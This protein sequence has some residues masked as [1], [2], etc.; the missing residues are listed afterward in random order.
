VALSRTD[1]EIID[2]LVVRLRAEHD[3]RAANAVERLMQQALVSPDPR[4]ALAGYMT[5]GEAARLIGVSAQTI[6]NWVAHGR[7]VGNRV[8]G[9]ILVARRSVQSFFDALG[10]AADA[11][12]DEDSAGADAAQRNVMEELPTGLADRV[13]ELLDRQRAGYKLSSSERTEL[14]RLARQGTA[15]ATRRT[16]ARIPVGRTSRA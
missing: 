4:A 16:R 13:E 2:E 6:K 14:R 7:L 1:A 15:T 5:T 9:R 3:E 8:G 10:T 12:E 11:S